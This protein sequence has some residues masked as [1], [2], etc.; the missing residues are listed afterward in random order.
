MRDFRLRIGSSMASDSRSL[1]EIANTVQMQILA[2]ADALEGLCLV[3]DN[4]F[5]F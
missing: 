4:I 2:A 3:S 1:R 5:K